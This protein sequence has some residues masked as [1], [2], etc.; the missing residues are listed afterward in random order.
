[1]ITDQLAQYYATIAKEYERIY[2]KPER[3][4]DLEGLREKV[5]DALEGHT[6][7]ELACGTG[8]WTEV[9]AE[10]ADSVLATD[11]NDEMLALA[12]E[13][14]LPDNVSLAKLDAFNLPDDLAGKFTAVFAGFWW[15]HV[16]KEDQEKYLKQL[17]AKLGKDV[18]LVLIDNSYVDGSSTVIAR[19]DLEGNTHQFRTTA[20]GERYEVL[21]N[22]PN[23]SHLR[24]KF[25][26]SARE[27]RMKRL[28]YYWFLSCRLK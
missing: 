21:K 15:S 5:A 14:E 19:T 16:K 27:I 24:K 7:L 6:V 26:N 2:D 22:F 23:D 17:R 13:R 4:E 28:E 12:R 8:Y 3:Q 1:M 10:V 11:I 25:A 18:L 9:I 20:S